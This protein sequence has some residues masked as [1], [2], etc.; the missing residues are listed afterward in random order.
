VAGHGKLGQTKP[1]A[2]RLA[3]ADALDEQG[4]SAIALLTRK[5]PQ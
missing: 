1:E 5:P 4:R 3:V 2:A